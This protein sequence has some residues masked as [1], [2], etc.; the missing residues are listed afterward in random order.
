MPKSPT[1]DAKVLA[2]MVNKLTPTK[3]KIF[4]DSVDDNSVKRRLISL[5]HKTHSDVQTNICSKQISIG[6]I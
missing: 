5:D 1:R 3:R 2:N 6:W 4:A